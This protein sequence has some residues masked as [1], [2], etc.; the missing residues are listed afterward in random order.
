M[1]VFTYFLPFT[2]WEL[3]HVGR[4]A[5]LL[6]AESE[7]FEKVRW[8]WIVRSIR[9]SQTLACAGDAEDSLDR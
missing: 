5:L 1:K 6:C 8:N 7:H 3:R 9:E 4:H 2:R